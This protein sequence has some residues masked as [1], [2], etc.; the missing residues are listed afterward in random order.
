[1]RWPSTNKLK[2]CVNAWEFFVS[3]FL[4]NVYILSYY[5]SSY[6]EN[7]R[8]ANID[9]LEANKSA[10]K[11]EIKRL[12]EENKDLRKKIAHLSKVRHLPLH[13]VLL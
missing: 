11:E 10:N 8:A 9:V 12:R 13:P 7:D 5:F 6:L 3:D 1:M 4:S 2:T